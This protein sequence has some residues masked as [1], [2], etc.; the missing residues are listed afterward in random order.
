MVVRALSATM[1]PAR[2]PVSRGRG[3]TMSIG[4][5][6]PLTEAETTRALPYLVARPVDGTPYG[7]WGYDGWMVMRSYRITRLTAHVVAVN[8]NYIH[9]KPYDSACVLV[10][11]CGDMSSIF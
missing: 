6:T 10:S 1:G 5:R 3:A 2:L 11:I 4:T 8:L 7:P 9:G